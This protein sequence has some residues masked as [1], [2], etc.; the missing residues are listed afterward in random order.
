MDLT[1]H[2][3]IDFVEV[4]Q[5]PAIAEAIGSITVAETLLSTEASQSAGDYLFT[6]NQ[7]AESW[8][9]EVVNVRSWAKEFRQNHPEL[10]FYKAPSKPGGKP[11]MFKYSS[12]QIELMEEEFR[13]QRTKPE[14]SKT[15]KDLAEEWAIF[16]VGID[17]VRRY[18][19]EFQKKYPDQKVR[20]QQSGTI[21]E[22]ILTEEQVGI[23]EN[24]NL[25][26]AEASVGSKT[27]NQL[28][29]D[30][31]IDPK[32]ARRYVLEF[33]R[34]HPEQERAKFKIRGADKF[35]T[36]LTPDQIELL[37]SEYSPRKP[38]QQT[39]LK[40]AKDLEQLWGVKRGVV[41]SVAKSYRRKYP[42]QE[43]IVG[44]TPTST[45]REYLYSL[46]QVAA[47]ERSRGIGLDLPE[48]AA[49]I[50]ELADRWDLSLSTVH[51][52]A[53]VLFGSGP[54][55]SLGK[56]RVPGTVRMITYLTLEQIS[57]LEINLQ[58]SKRYISGLKNSFNELVAEMGEG[59][60]DVAKDLLGM[61]QLFG[62][63]RAVDI[64]FQYRPEYRGLPVPYVRS[65]LAE[66]LGDYL[67]LPGQLYL[68]ELESAVEYLSDPSLRES[69]VEVIKNSCLRVCHAKK[70]S[71][72][73][74]DDLDVLVDHLEGLRQQTAHYNSDV[75]AE[76]IDEVEAYY[77]ALFFDIKIPPTLINEFR[78][79]R[80]FP[81]LNQRVNIKELELKQ[82]IL[83][84]DDTGV[85]KSASAILAKESLGVRQ[86]L[87]VAPS[88][89]IEVWRKYLTD[90]R[91]A[92]GEQEGYFNEGLAPSVLI[93]ESL[94]DLYSANPGDH[95]Y[96]IISQERLTDEYTEAL[97]SFDYGM[98]IV[99]EVHKLKNLIGGKRAEN[100][101]KLASRVEYE[102]DG[103][104][105][106]LALLSATPVPN[107]IGDIAM[108]L[109]LLYP[110][111]FAE[112]NNQD[113]TYQILSGD[114]LDL[115]TLL[116]PRMQMKSLSETVEMPDLVEIEHTFGLSDQEKKVYEILLEQDELSATEK[117]KIL[118]QF[119]LNPAFFD[120]TPDIESS[121][122]KEVDAALAQA[123]ASKDKVVMFVNDYI[124]G[125]I[126][127]GQTIFDGIELPDSV[128]L[129][130]IHG[131][132]SK[133]Q[134]LAIQKM[135]KEPDRR[136]LLAVSGQ[137]ADV[138]VDFSAA[139]EVFFYNEP[140]T[141][142]D[143]K[144]ELGR[145]F[146]PGLKHDLVAR[147]FYAGGTIE[148]GIH[149]YIEVKYNAVEKL[150]RGIPLSE[151]ERQLLKH[152]EQGDQHLD[153]NPDL[154]EFYISSWERMLKIF[155]HVKEIGEPGF[156]NFLKRF[157]KE[158]AECYVDL[159]SRSYQAN[160]NRVAGS[161]IDKFA[162]MRGQPTEFTR[163]LDVASGPEMLRKHIGSDYQEQVVSVDINP[164]H[165]TE[166]GPKQIVG[167]FLD[168]PIADKTIDYVNLSLALHYTNFVPSKGN[169]ERLQALKEL[170]RVLTTGGRAVINM[171]YSLEFRDQA[172]LRQ[173]MDRIG[174]KVLDEYSGT[175]RA[176]QSF[177]AGLLVLEKI[178][179]CP[180]DVEA[181]ANSMGGS[182]L[183]GLKFRRNNS[184]L[185]ST[186]KII[187]SFSVG[188][189][190][191]IEV[192]LNETDQK[193]LDEEKMILQQASQ[194][195]RRHG[196][197]RDI[198]GEIVIKN[199]FARVFN[200]RVYVLFKKL[201]S[202]PGAVITQ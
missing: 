167:S 47:M 153:V 2:E 79:G 33:F 188:E 52:R 1:R 17:K 95:E 16:G 194:L 164:L 4:E 114:V 93:V 102:N 155:G 72:P 23:I 55:Q 58:K 10:A 71:E 160:A 191:K 30:W 131:E 195:K 184:R 83:I 156:V 146:R 76:I 91:G 45:R 66:Y 50:K 172:A 133:E 192:R 200:G 59:E 124:E 136:M 48:G 101:I 87:I 157:A 27:I 7:L 84:A 196:S 60:S 75:L 86:A 36:H 35:T 163:I 150:L 107:K 97:T 89:V 110:E 123:F 145:V 61:I 168:L 180:T 67:L 126:R 177:R 6:H 63:E 92:N 130:V 174:F 115:R 137:T 18:I 183:Q 121:K 178:S 5:E 193:V 34:S 161:L 176:G 162:K 24:D 141:K 199:G 88:N 57:F 3:E 140:W 53:Q 15:A 49:T 128:E 144:Q 117:F 43:Y 181:L 96:V 125:V 169:L 179:D 158:Y 129:H 32:S 106:Y 19:Y 69:L 198:P 120:P 116:V 54:E 12:D 138:G 154:A 148:E 100:L 37:E 135:L 119:V 149:K 170:N 171:M 21:R 39:D 81:D 51:Q 109:R 143:K 8:G 103:E 82:R 187:T 165:F 132:V 29:L 74:A 118:R 151:L 90:T 139:E 46:E 65:M 182:I 14:N 31:D 190:K 152:D 186:R 41:L 44:K 62:A 185:R 127:G 40:T 68:E 108:V 159:G 73:S 11:K 122:I 112:I 9:M 42:D 147:T 13:L 173:A 202:G 80:P 22:I 20:R 28:A 26:G 105:K 189:G 85:G 99:D 134:R 104:K 64:L 175:A 197:I 78:D 56:F 113:L 70:D 166:T 38:T 77:W 111:R 98:L 201:E 25:I 142:Y 94:D